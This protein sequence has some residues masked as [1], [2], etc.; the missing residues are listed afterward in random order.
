MVCCRNWLPVLHMDYMDSVSNID[1]G[2]LSVSVMPE[3]LVTD[4]GIWVDKFAC[5]RHNIE[6]STLHSSLCKG[7][8]A[9]GNAAADTQNMNSLHT[10]V[11]NVPK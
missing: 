5:V 9:M 3:W 4:L 8:H 6:L 1:R 7:Q 11:I 10:M 2:C